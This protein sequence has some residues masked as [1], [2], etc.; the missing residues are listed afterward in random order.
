[1]FGLDGH[2]LSGNKTLDE[3][4]RIILQNHL[5]EFAPIN[6]AVS[7]V[8]EHGCKSTKVTETA[9]NTIEELINN[10]GKYIESFSEDFPSIKKAMETPKH[11]E[12][13][14]GISSETTTDAIA[15]ALFFIPLPKIKVFKVIKIIAP[16]EIEALKKTTLKFIRDDTGTTATLQKTVKVDGKGVLEKKTIPLEKDAIKGT[17]KLLVQHNPEK[18][19]SIWVDG[20]VITESNG[21]RAAYGAQTKTSG[22]T[23]LAL[24]K[25]SE[26]A[27]EFK[28]KNVIIQSD[29]VNDKLLAIAMKTKRLEYLGERELFNPRIFDWIVNEKYPTFKYN[30]PNILK[31]SSFFK[32]L[33]SQKSNIFSFSKTAYL[34]RAFKNLQPTEE[35]LKKK[36]FTGP[37]AIGHFNTR[38]RIELEPLIS[39]LDTEEFSTKTLKKTDLAKRRQEYEASQKQEP[40][41]VLQN[42]Y[43]TTVKVINEVKELLPEGLDVRIENPTNFKQMSVSVIQPVTDDMQV[44]ANFRPGKIKSSTLSFSH[45]V[46]KFDPQKNPNAVTTSL[47]VNLNPCHIKKST[48]SLTANNAHFTAG[49]IIKP[50]NLKNSQVFGS[51]PVFNNKGSIGF[52][53]TLKKPLKGTVSASYVVPVAGVVPVKL[54]VHVPLSKPLNTAVTASIPLGICDL[55]VLTLSARKISIIGISIFDKDKKKRKKARRKAKEAARVAMENYLKAVKAWELDQKKVLEILPHGFTLAKNQWMVNETVEYSQY[56]ANIVQDWKNA[57]SRKVFSADCSSF[58]KMIQN[59]LEGKFFSEVASL[60]PL[61]HHSTPIIP[62]EFL[63]LPK[64]FAALNV[65]T[66]ANVEKM[67]ETNASLSELQ[68]N[69]SETHTKFA[70]INTEFQSTNEKLQATHEKYEA[71][72]Q[73][74]KENNVELSE[75]R[76]LKEIAIESFNENVDALKNARQREAIAMQ[77]LDQLNQ[78]VAAITIE[79]EEDFRNKPALANSITPEMRANLLAA[80]DANF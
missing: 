69:L 16:T 44:G 1:M 43:T 60:S 18:S 20:L 59:K 63:D 37:I 51:A 28:V 68:I 49:A 56:H 42:I 74:L 14:Y 4:D 30:I 61:A 41:P 52:S 70:E 67:K 58:V 24:Q 13:K 19:V 38:E 15:G 48:F 78:D 80:L 33:Y 6:R 55:P 62:E 65:A 46:T 32:E 2:Q 25:I 57:V 26:L 36:P 50:R 47:G 8:I 72:N 7:A 9:C 77:Q 23:F 10:A 71:S 17:L 45:N 75:V 5:E 53:G 11:I 76:E 22:T 40:E 3:S 54:G 64:E 31:E 21:A 29:I 79:L 35:F 12:Q 34:S 66:V 73:K 27:K 39:N